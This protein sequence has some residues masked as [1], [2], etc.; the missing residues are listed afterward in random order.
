MKYYSMMET[1]QLFRTVY[2]ETFP[3]THLKILTKKVM[4][5]CMNAALAASA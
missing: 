2:E 3:K 4:L 5:L 1:F